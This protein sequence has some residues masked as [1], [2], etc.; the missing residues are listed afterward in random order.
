[1]CECIEKTTNEVEKHILKEIKRE[2]GFQDVTASYFE[3]VPF[4]IVGSTIEQ[5][6][7]ALPFIV[8]YQRKGKKSGKVRTYKKNTT[9][10][11]TYCPF[12]GEEYK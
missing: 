6:K 1:M 5:R 4:L 8:E 10:F 7:I 9:V 2:I 12:C 11:P 3:N